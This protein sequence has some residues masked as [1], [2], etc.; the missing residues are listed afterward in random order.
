ML[1]ASTAVQSRCWIVQ[2]ISLHARAQ[3]QSFRPACRLCLCIS[4]PALWLCSYV[5]KECLAF[6]CCRIWLQICRQAVNRSAFKCS[7]QQASQSKASAEPAGYAS[8]EYHVG[9]NMDDCT[10]VL[11]QPGLECVAELAIRLHR[12]CLCTVCRTHYPVPSAC[13]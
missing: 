10:D 5:R 3:N 8:P 11:C 13:R 12:S 7:F 1:T 6:P 2:V 4:D 9:P